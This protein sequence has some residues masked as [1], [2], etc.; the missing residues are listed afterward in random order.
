MSDMVKAI[1]VYDSPVWHTAG[2]A[3]SAISYRGPFHEFHDHSGPDASGTA[4]IFGFARSITLPD[5]TDDDIGA[6]SAEAALPLAVL[7]SAGN[8]RIHWAS[9]ETADAFS[10]HI[11]G[12]LRAGLAP[13]RSIQDL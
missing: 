5:A 11:E 2:L 10:G 3:G 9:T 1:A 4:A 12:A 13:A 7:N 8:K 6:S